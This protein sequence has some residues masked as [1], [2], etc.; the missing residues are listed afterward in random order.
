MGRVSY[1]SIETYWSCPY[2][3]KLRYIDKLKTKPDTSPS[4]ALYEGTAIHEAIEKRSIVEGMNT[5]RSNY[6]E[7]NDEHYFEMYKLE[8]A[9]KKGIDQVPEGE[10]EYKL[11]NDT[12]IGFID[13]LV[14]VEDGV[15]DLYDFKYSQNVDGYKK[16]GQVHIYAYYYEYLTKNKIRNIYYVF[17]PKCPIKY[18]E[19]DDINILKQKVDE[20]YNKNDVRFEQIEF[21]RQHISYF[22]ARQKMLEKETAFEKRY[23]FKCNW[24]EYQNYCKTNGADKSE[25]EIEDD[26]KEVD[27]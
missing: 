19:N 23:S 6:K 5:Y 9:M 4:C 17:I 10:Y 7:I 25:L 12:F 24:C 18:D 21:D 26:V 14:K 20:F 11:V 2:H 15:Y 8:K 3:Y 13:M 1:S 27:L 16:S 22:F